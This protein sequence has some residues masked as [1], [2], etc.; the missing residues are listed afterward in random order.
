MAQFAISGQR[1]AAEN[2]M[3]IGSDYSKISSALIAALNKW[4]ATI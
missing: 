3:G 1:E 2:A 4:K